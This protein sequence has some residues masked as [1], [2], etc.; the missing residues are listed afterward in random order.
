MAIRL[1]PDVTYFMGGRVDMT[2][3]VAI[4]TSDACPRFFR[5]PVCC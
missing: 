4:E 2:I 5:P 1:R 3:G